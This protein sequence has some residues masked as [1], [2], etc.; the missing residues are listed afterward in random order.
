V[1]AFAGA[2][3]VYG[4]ERDHAVMWSALAQFPRPG[5]TRNHFTSMADVSNIEDLTRAILAGR[6]RGG[7]GD[8]HDHGIYVAPRESRHIRGD[9]VLTLTDQLRQRQWPDV[10][11]IAFSNHDVKGQSGSDWLRIGLIPPNLEIE[12]PYRALT[13]RGLDGIL[14]VGKALSATHDALPAI[15][16]QA[17]LENLGGVAAL[18]AVAAVQTGSSLRALDLGM[19]QARLVERGVLPARVLARSLAEPSSTDAELRR[20]IENLPVFPLHEYSDMELTDRFDGLIPLVEICCA[21]PRVVPLLEAAHECAQG[22]RKLRLAQMLALTG[23][24]AGVPTLIEAILPQLDGE[25]LPARTAHIRYTQLPPDHGAMPEV[26]HLLYSLGM[27]PDART[28]PVW[29][30]LAE[31]LADVRE[32]DFYEDMKGTFYYVDA[33]GYSAERLAS[34][35]LIPLLSRIRAAGPF[36]QRMATTAFEA[37]FVLERLA[38][39]ELVLGRA[40]ARCGAVEGYL[41]LVAYLTD[42]RALL[43]EHAHT[44]LKAITGEDYGKDA[45]AWSQWIEL[46]ADS[47]V[48]RPCPPRTEAMD[49]WLPQTPV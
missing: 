2:D 41:V 34:P 35:A 17:D 6:R 46:N 15:R 42:N 23:S 32:P 36:H 7:K 1:A 39:L 48:P 25:V 14:V 38:Y 10:V 20:M 19:L 18:A 21:G 8:M 49:S 40:L 44:E 47:L 24:N 27:T 31:L 22:E 28:L 12:I 5:L 11:N 13:P 9:V 43:A 33:F 30:R 29:Q 37:D 45:S 4:S 3:F 16:M 26:V